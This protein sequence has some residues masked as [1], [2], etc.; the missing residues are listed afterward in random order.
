MGLKRKVEV[1]EGQKVIQPKQHP[2]EA[3][4]HYWKNLLR[5]AYS[6]RLPKDAEEGGCGVTGFACNIP[7]SGRHIFEPSVQMH[8]RGNGKGGGIAAVGLEADK[9]GVDQET[10][11]EDFLLQIALLDETVLPD[12]EEQF[13]RPHFQ[14]D[15][16]AFLQTIDDYRDLPGL[17]MKPPAVKRYFVRVKPDVSR[18]FSKRAAAWKTFRPKRR[19][20]N[21]SIR[22]PFNSTRATT[23]PW[24]KRGPL[25]FPTAA[26]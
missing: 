15:H 13:I 18:P 25:S 14:V 20:R 8:N 24:G 26:T 3:A 5:P 17:E 21:S 22:I 16:E 6:A 9:L 19:K 11:E 2:G 1:R 23:A 7:V 4:A 12:L 10:L